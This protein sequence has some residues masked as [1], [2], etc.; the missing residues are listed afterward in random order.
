MASFLVFASQTLTVLSFD[1]ETSRRL[2][3]DHAI[4]YTAPTWPKQLP[5]NLPGGRARKSER[6]V[7]AVIIFLFG[8]LQKALD[9]C[10]RPIFSRSYQTTHWQSWIHPG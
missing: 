2:S 5:R 10:A 1:A 7:V 4:W 9:L 8:L 3:L 6:R